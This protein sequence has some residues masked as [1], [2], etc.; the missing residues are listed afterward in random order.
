MRPSDIRGIQR[1]IV[2]RSI[3]FRFGEFESR[4]F[5]PAAATAM[6]VESSLTHMAKSR[7]L[8]LPSTIVFLLLA[9]I[10]SGSPAMAASNGQTNLSSV[11]PEWRFADF[12]GDYK[13]DLIQLHRTFLELRLS[14]GKELHL[15]SVVGSE[16]PG[17]EIVVVD[18]DG[19][20]DFDIVVRNRF[21]KQHTAIWLN[22]GMGLFTKSAT[23]GFS[24]P[25]EHGSWSQSPPVDPGAVLIVRISRPLTVAGDAWLQPPPSSTRKLHSDSEI[26]TAQVH[27][28][29]SHLRGPP[30]PSL[31]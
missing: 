22:D 10:A 24:F 2:S 4:S 15:A 19:D 29:T 13:P 26:H 21:L 11:A 31:R 6:G 20:N 3:V 9:V 14:T 8:Y 16:A 30:I 18:L 5:G 27:T 28:D 7:P 1:W 23:R 25:F 17:A 12:D